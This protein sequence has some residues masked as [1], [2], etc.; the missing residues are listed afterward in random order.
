M[1]D[2]IALSWGG[3]ARIGKA[4]FAL[5][6]HLVLPADD[7]FTTDYILLYIREPKTRFRTARH[8][9]AK[10]DQPQLMRVI[11]ITFQHLKQFQK[12]MAFF[13]ANDAC[14]VFEPAEG[15]QT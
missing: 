7:D 9:V 14:T 12:N 10:L 8:Q 6:S 11:E 5:R 15:K 4:I 3:I 2:M 13:W 1:A